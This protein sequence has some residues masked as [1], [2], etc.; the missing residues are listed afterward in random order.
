MPVA[1]YR[2]HMKA[3]SWRAAAP[4]SLAESRFGRH[5]LRVPHQETAI[6]WVGLDLYQKYITACALDEAGRVVAEH[7]R[8]PAD[9]EALI[10]WLTGL[11]GPVTVAMEVTLYWAWLHDQPTAANCPRCRMR[12]AAKPCDKRFS[13][14]A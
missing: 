9:A 14:V 7:R 4:G 10:S 8:L 13:S 5:L 6:F 11:G 2:D 12:L 1:A 3:R